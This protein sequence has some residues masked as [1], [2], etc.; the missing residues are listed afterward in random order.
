VA[1]EHNA[2]RM[3]GGVLK[4]PKARLAITGYASSP[5]REQLSLGLLGIIDSD[6]EVQLLRIGR[7][8]PSWRDLVSDS[9]EGELPEAGLR[10]NDYPAIDVFVD[11]HA[12]Y[13]TIELREGQRV[14]TVDNG[15]LQAS[16]SHRE[17]GTAKVAGCAGSG[18]VSVRGPAAARLI[19]YIP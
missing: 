7:V 17:H 8:W 14:R 1:T 12:E 19:A 2:E 5:E 16:R 4:D 13:L 6:I 11:C 3:S 10:A 18:I 15:L 9:L